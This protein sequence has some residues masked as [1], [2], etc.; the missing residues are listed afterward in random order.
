MQITPKKILVIRLSAMGDVAMAVPVINT[1]LTQNPLVEVTVVSRAFFKPL[2]PASDRLHFYAAD[3]KGKHKGVM[4]LYKLY[5]EL[6]PHKFDAIADI[7]DLL[8]SKILRTFFSLSKIDIAVINKGRKEKKALTAI[9]NKVFK[10][11]KTTHQRYADV[12]DQINIP[13]DLSNPVLS[14]KKELNSRIQYHI[15]Y[16]NDDTLVGIAPFAAH[17][18]KKYPLEQMQKVID[19]LIKKHNNSKII[20]FG[21]GKKEAKILEFIA[22]KYDNTLNIANKITLEEELALISNLDCMVA[23][24]SGNAHFAAMFGIPTITIWGATHPFAGFY[25]FNQLDN[26]ITANR[27]KY[28]LLPTS[29]YGNKQVEGYEKVMDTISPEQVVHKVLE[30]LK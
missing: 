30:V 7:H 12:F 6:K 15:E 27:E 9:E 24:D 18:G 19:Q 17:E 20:L 3:V 26:C 29:I 23:M 11:L 8:R 28:P 14:T 1:L 25:P 13:V 2:F 5:K 16:K 10:Q 22:E 21:G 4:G